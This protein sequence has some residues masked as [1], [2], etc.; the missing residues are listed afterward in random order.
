MSTKNIQIPEQLF[1]SASV[2]LSKRDGTEDEMHMSISSDVPYKRYDWMNDEY[3]W[4]VL[5]H[6]R[7]ACDETRLKAGL[8]IL[9]NHDT[10][11][12]LARATSFENDGKKITVSGLKWSSSEFAQE[13][14]A[15]AMNGSLPDTSVGYRITDDGECI[16]AKD[17]C[18]IYKFKWAPH[19]A[20]LVTVPADTTVGVGRGVKPEGMITRSVTFSV[21]N[22]PKPATNAPTHTPMADPIAPTAPET[23]SINIVAERQ[24]A[25]ATE[26]KRVADIQELN[27]H[28]TQKGIAGRRVDAGKLAERMIADGKTV[29]DFRNEVIRT[30][31]PELK[32]IET[33]P[34][35]G[36]SKRDL[37]GYSIVR[38]M[39][40]AIGAMKGQSWSGLEKDASEA[41]AKIA[42]R[43]TQGFF[44]PHDVMQSRALTTN[45]FSAAGAFV[46]TSAQGQS[47]IELYRNKMHVVALGAR[48]LTGLQGNLAIPSQTGGATA[49]WLSE[50]AT[51]TA[52]AQ[53]VGQ[54][55]LTPHRLAGATAFT[56]QLLAQSSQDVEN[57]VRNDLMTV[58]A[59]EKDRAALKGTGASG[60]PLGIYGTPNKSTSVTLAG[61]NSMTYANA[62]QFETNVALNNADMGSLGYLTSVQAKANSKLIA[63]INSTNSNPVW[64]GDMVNGY[65][66]RATNQLTTLPS[67][68]FGN[69]SDLIIGD[70]AS[71]EVIVD[72]YS[73]SMQG[74]VRIVMQQLTDVAIR[75]AKSFSISTT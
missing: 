6:G 34:E 18:P 71:N 66:A 65:T 16:G 56:Y 57:F 69:W 35:V 5:D 31:L 37:S 15:D 54:V 7:G 43:S 40:G 21:D 23:P 10:D 39:N 38:A 45:V 9:F 58:L 50:D 74:Q 75:H 44:I 62:V 1:R 68:I 64:K 47:L 55:S 52:S 24:S 17:G 3:Y 13:K 30:E 27:T 8:P 73:L 12:H 46:D 20:S 36:M 70:W 11:K 33:S 4:E 42:G 59:I 25:V 29:D 14:K 2:E 63:E 28:F 48:V 51:I 67:V 61:A 60:E 72:P 41:A 32:P 53:T 19:E 22:K 49:S 26:R